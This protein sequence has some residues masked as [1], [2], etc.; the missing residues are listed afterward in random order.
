MAQ[1]IV[2][3]KE[4]RRGPVQDGSAKRYWCVF[5]APRDTTTGI[6]ARGNAHPVD[7]SAVAVNVTPETRGAATLYVVEYVVYQPSGS[8]I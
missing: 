7:T 5:T 6:P 1:L 3:L 8:A 2:E 4:R